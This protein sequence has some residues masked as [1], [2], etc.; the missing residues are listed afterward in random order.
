MTP[1]FTTTTTFTRTH[2][3]HLAAKVIAD[4][5]Q[6][7][8]MYDDP[9]RSHVDECETELVE[10]LANSYVA[11]YEFG[12]KKNDKRIVSWRYTVGPDG[13]LHGDDNSGGIYARASVADGSY[14][15]FISYSSTWSKLTNTQQTT[16]KNG[17]PFQ[18]STGTLPA[19]GDGYWVVDHG[20]T[21]GGVRVA[22][23][24][25]RPS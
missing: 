17:L 9:A 14:F 7:H 22:R 15:N 20:Y 11:T 16:F 2:A 19:D 10:M 1:T 23:S 3:K 13:G 24:T 6:C 12:F 25:F 21:A 4:L 18:R 5:Y 8:L